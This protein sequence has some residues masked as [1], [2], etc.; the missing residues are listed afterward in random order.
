MDADYLID[1]RRLKR[2]LTVWRTAAIVAIV[3]AIGA[4]V[5]DYTGVKSGDY[6]ARLNIDSI[7]HNDLKRLSVI[8]EIRKDDN[9]KALIVRINSP[10]GTVVGG[11]AL[12]RALNRVRKEKPV[13]AVMDELATSAGYMVAVASDR[14]IA[15]EGTITGSIGV[16]FQTAEVTELLSKLGVKFEAIKSAPL[17]AEPSPFSKVTPKVREATKLLVDDMYS[18]FVDMI[19]KNRDMTLEKVRGLADGRV[20]TGRMALKNG[21]VDEI[22]NERQAKRWLA[23]EKKIDKSIP[24]REIRVRREVEDW[25]D[26]ASSIVQKTSLSERLILDGLVSVWHPWLQ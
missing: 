18:M 21:L 17:K 25:L 11:E 15:H 16:L 22:G 3:A 12:H 20:Y 1:R 8:D 2:R 24:I 23:S 13:I 26:Y 10:G 9:A 6:I 4:S 14:I 5:F 7:I 19:V